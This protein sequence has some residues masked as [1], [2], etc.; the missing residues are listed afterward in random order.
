VDNINHE[1]SKIFHD[2]HN[3]STFLEVRLFFQK[4]NPNEINDKQTAT[5]GIAT[6]TAIVVVFVFFAEKIY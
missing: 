1:Q 2:I 3:T 6:A 4:Q 5:T